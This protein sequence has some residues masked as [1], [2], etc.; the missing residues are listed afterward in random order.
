MVPQVVGTN[1]TFD[2]T[3]EENTDS[4]LPNLVRELSSR[5]RYKMPEISDG[6][7]RHALRELRIGSR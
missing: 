4:M 1:L 6:R 2:F 7:G 3:N 5:G